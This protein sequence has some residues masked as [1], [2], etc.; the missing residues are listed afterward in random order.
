MSLGIRED[1]VSQSDLSVL[2]GKSPRDCWLALNEEQTSVVGRGESIEE[3]MK[4][5]NKNGVADPVVIWAPKNWTPS[6]FRGI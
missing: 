1:V 6:V 5:A 2:L 3:A 4:E